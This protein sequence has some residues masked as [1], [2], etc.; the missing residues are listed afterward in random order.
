M[1]IIV[2]NKNYGLKK[3]GNICKKYHGIIGVFL[4]LTPREIR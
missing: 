2:K 1:E 3:N 4:K